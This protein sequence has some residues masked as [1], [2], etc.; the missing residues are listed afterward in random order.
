MGTATKTDNALKTENTAHY[1]NRQAIDNDPPQSQQTVNQTQRSAESIGELNM[2]SFDENRTNNE[3]ESEN[4]WETA[5]HYHRT[6]EGPCTQSQSLSPSLNSELR[7]SKAESLTG[8]TD[9]IDPSAVV[10]QGSLYLLVMYW[11]YLFPIINQITTKLLNRH[12]FLFTFLGACNLALQGCWILAVFVWFNKPSQRARETM[13]LHTH[14]SDENNEKAVVTGNHDQKKSS[15]ILRR[16][17]S[18]KSAASFNIFD[19]S[20]AS[21]QFAEFVFSD[22]DSYEIDDDIENDIDEEMVENDIDEEMVE[23][24]LDEEMIE[25]D[26]DEEMIDD[27]VEDHNDDATVEAVARRH[28]SRVGYGPGED[29][30]DSMYWSTIQ[31]HV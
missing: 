22:D 25:T 5:K 2:P 3:R 15:P 16:S 20:N 28:S 10:R 30:R 9:G 18:Y 6:D 31:D 11:S 14:G 13:I 29:E 8:E 27:G 26:I 23:T 24:D 4:S 17:E 12:I 19:G 7:Q 1:G 21:D